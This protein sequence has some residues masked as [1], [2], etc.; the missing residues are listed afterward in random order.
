MGKRANGEGSV[1]QRANGRWEARLT[2]TDT[3]TGQVK[4]ASF[5]G[6][7]AKA[8]RAEMKKARERLAAGAPVKD[9]STTV[10]DWLSHWRATT[11][12]ASDRKESTRALYRTAVAQHLQP[13]PFGATTTRQATAVGC[14]GAV[15]AMRAKTKAGPTD[16]AEPVRAL[17]DSTT[18]HV[19]RAPACAGWRGTRRA[20]GTQSGRPGAPYGRGTHL[21]LG[22]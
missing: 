2:Y 17:S 20:A 14:R 11:L 18:E 9:A 8:A 22:T 4:R 10:G 16:E 6:A 5:Y 7:T 3:E 1:R 19:H 12:A 15:F 13:A 21:R